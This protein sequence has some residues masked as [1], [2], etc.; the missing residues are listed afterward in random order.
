GKRFARIFVRLDK[1]TVATGGHRCAREHRRERAVAGSARARAAGSLHG[2]RRIENNVKT[3]FANPIKRAHVRDEIVV[4]E[5][6]AAFREEKF[7]ASEAAD[8]FRDIFQI[9]RREKL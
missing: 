5:G 1:N 7:V 3:S 2:M 4:A 6:C 8:F 9:P